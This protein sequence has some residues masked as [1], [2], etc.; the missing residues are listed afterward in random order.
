MAYKEFILS[1]NQPVRIYKRRQ[2]RNLR[3]TID[4]SG[5]IKVSVPSWA[6]YKAGLDFANSKRRWIES[7]LKPKNLLADG[8]PIGK[9]H[10]LS[11]RSDPKRHKPATRLS[12]NTIIV[13]HPIGSFLTDHDVQKAAEKASIRA[14]KNQSESLL[15]QRLSFLAAKHGLS[16][17]KVSIKQ[18]K[19]RWG[20]C[21]MNKDIVLNLFLMQVPWELIDYVLLHELTHTEV[22][23]HGPEFWEY[24]EHVLPSA[25]NYR[26]RLREFQPVLH[27]SAGPAVS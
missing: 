11:F 25:K 13:S 4:A 24:M 9:A 17:N 27:G 12:G 6:T 19:S 22:L 16:Y 23:K 26:K 8:Q 10:H 3:L 7:N 1:N 21:D 14:L 2:A 20:S 18:M 5:Q 15:P